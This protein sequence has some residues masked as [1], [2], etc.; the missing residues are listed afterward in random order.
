MGWSY[1]LKCSFFEVYQKDVF[2][3]STAK[4]IQISDTG[5]RVNLRG[6][7]VHAVNS[8]E[9]VDELLIRA[10]KN[11]KVGSTAMNARSSRSH[12]IFQLLIEGT[13]VSG[14]KCCGTLSL[15]D[16]AGSENIESLKNKKQVDECK[17]ILSSLGALKTALTRLREG[18][19]PTFRDSKLTH[20][21][22][23]SLTAGSKVLMFVNVAPEKS[24]LQET[25]SSLNFGKSVNAIKLGS[26]KSK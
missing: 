24:C 14:R 17:E 16:L 20:V 4:A 6:L 8:V 2:D 13:H 18:K 26:G 5:D 10:K 21:L 15:V 22:K 9:Q 12:F 7:E 25:K 19:T 3:L 23:N 1:S 11:R